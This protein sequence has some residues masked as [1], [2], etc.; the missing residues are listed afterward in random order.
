MQHHRE[1]SPAPGQW[2]TY[3]ESNQQNF[4]RKNPTAIPSLDMNSSKIKQEKGVQGSQ[5]GVI[6]G[7]AEWPGC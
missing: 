1:E 4:G 5:R 7:N 2:K 3:L 6:C